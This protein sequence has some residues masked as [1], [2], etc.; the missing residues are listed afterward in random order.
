MQA[1]VTVTAFTSEKPRRLVELENSPSKDGCTT[2]VANCSESRPLYKA[3]STLKPHTVEVLVKY[4]LERLS[5]YG[6]PDLASWN[7]EVSETDG[8]FQVD[9]VNNKGAGFS[10]DSIIMRPN[11]SAVTV[12]H[13][14][15]AYV[16]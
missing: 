5:V 4:A 6:I 1:N 15:S 14:I 7:I 9:L 12:D 3:P 11:R 8:W 16:R 10:V 2:I 13:G